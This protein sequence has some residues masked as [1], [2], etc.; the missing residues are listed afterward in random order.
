[1]PTRRVDDNTLPELARL[2]NV[3]L[4]HE[5]ATTSSTALAHWAIQTAART[6]RLP[7]PDAALSLLTDLALAEPSSDGS[8]KPSQLLLGNTRAVGR[9]LDQFSPS[10]A[11]CVFRRLLQHPDYSGPLQFALSYAS[12]GRGELTVAWN[13]VARRDRAAPSWRWL[14]ELGLLIHSGSAV[15]FDATLRSFVIDFPPA[16]RADVTGRA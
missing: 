14:Q 11:Q 10:L 4:Q 13:A 15:T 16:K 8:L 9:T 3:W 5:L 7:N 12:I 6:P 1:M 2:L